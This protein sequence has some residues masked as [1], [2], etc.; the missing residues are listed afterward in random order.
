MIPIEDIMKELESIAEGKEEYSQTKEEVV[1]VEECK[2]EN[3]SV[4][5]NEYD[6]NVVKQAEDRGFKCLS[7]KDNIK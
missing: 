4:E 2:D 3:T 7:N 1:E 6:I 5:L